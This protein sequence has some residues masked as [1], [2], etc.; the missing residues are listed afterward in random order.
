MYSVGA[1]G[2]SGSFLQPGRLIQGPNGGI[3]RRGIR[4]RER[5]SR[6]HHEE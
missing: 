4:T 2:F 3:G 5:K 6:S 1:R